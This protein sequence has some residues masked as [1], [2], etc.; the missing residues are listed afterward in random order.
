M[1]VSVIIGNNIGV[2]GVVSTFFLNTY[3]TYLALS[4]RP[5]DRIPP[6]HKDDAMKKKITISRAFDDIPLG[7]AAMLPGREAQAAME[8]ATMRNMRRNGEWYNVT[9]VYNGCTGYALIQ[10]REA[11][12]AATEELLLSQHRFFASTNWL[13]T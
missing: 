3:L 5:G 11:W 1:S 4:L 7:G 6:L 8:E 10:R 13:Q 9:L 12:E 2:A